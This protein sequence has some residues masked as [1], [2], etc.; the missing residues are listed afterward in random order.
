MLWVTIYVTILPIL[1]VS[2]YAVFNRIFHI[3]KVI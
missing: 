2:I 1:N 3:L